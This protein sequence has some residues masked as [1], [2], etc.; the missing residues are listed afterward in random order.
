MLKN[1]TVL[2]AGTLLLNIFSTQ[3]QAKSWYPSGQPAIYNGA[4]S[5]SAC[6]SG[7]PETENNANTAYGILFGNAYDDD[8]GTLAS[9]YLSLEPWDIDRDG[10]SNGQELR[11]ASGYF[12]SAAII[13]TLTNPDMTDVYGNVSAKA[14]DGG[15]A[16]AELSIT[17]S[18]FANDI[19][20]FGK[21]SIAN[22]VTTTT[23]MYKFG[24][25]QTG[26]TATFY[27][28]NN[29]P[30][31]A[32]TA[33]GSSAPNLIPGDT[34]LDGSMNIL[35]KDEGVF[36][37]YTTAKLQAAAIAKYNN[38]PIALGAATNVPATATVDP[39]AKV[40]PT[41]TID[42]YAVI[43]AYAVVDDY[44]VIGP[45]AQVGSYAYIAANVDLYSA[46]T[47]NTYAQVNPYAEVT[48][49]ITAPSTVIAS[50]NGVGYVQAK[51]SITTTAPAVPTI[52]GGSGGDDND[53]EGGGDSGGLHCMATGLGLQGL[54]FLSLFGI[55]SLLRRKK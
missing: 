17:G 1:Q 51:F 9:A 44:A 12:D 45:Y 24:G 26:A 2:I 39:Y 54:I 38:S 4:I 15:G 20:F 10:F 13:P 14:V 49:N 47:I 7:S 52:V 34:T 32:N 37:L 21:P 8:R 46:G 18:S 11:Q 33:D 40:S 23:F 25:M 3:A 42:D 41:A 48:A 27:D 53:G 50:P 28:E 55:A 31:A 6:H 22:A 16:V 35:V 30:I 43:D 19:T 5:C 36:D 29:A